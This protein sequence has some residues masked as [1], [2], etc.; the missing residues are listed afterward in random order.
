MCV[1]VCTHT[2]Y[3]SLVEKCVFWARIECRGVY[4]ILLEFLLFSLSHW[5][6]ALVHLDDEDN[7]GSCGRKKTVAKSND[8]KAIWP[9]VDFS[10]FV[11][12]FSFKGHKETGPWTIINMRSKRARKKVTE[13]E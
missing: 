3:V 11:F 6:I 12:F 7:I 13:K 1:C 8:N 10:N 9:C 5:F 4:C 2:V